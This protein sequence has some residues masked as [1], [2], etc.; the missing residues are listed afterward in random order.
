MK[1]H[2]GTAIII[3]IFLT[4]FS[5]LAY[6]FVSDFFNSISQS[7]A[8][9]SY[10]EAVK[11]ASES[12]L[13]D[14]MEAARAYNARLSRSGV[15]TDFTEKELM[16]YTGL[17]NLTP[18]GIM[19][20]LEIRRINVLLPIYHGTSDGALQIGIGHLEGYS[21]PVGGG[22]THTVLT[23]HRGLPSSTLLTNLDRLIAGDVFEIHVLNETLYYL[24]DQIL[25]V[26]PKDMSI[27]K[28]EPE[29][30]LCTI[31]TCTPYGIN[32]HRLLVRGRR[33]D[34]P[35]AMKALEIYSEATTMNTNWVLAVAAIPVVI[36]VVVV[37]LIRWR[38]KQARDAGIRERG[39]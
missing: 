8:V 23:G 36:I 20:T 7:R 10:G 27:L 31:V 13:T 28:I 35:E 24:V 33:I 32:S 25:V 26:E 37:Q 9:A 16:E 15:R 14:I 34:G 39:L 5:I 21:L 11:K 19:G 2:L 12:E 29:M 3:L 17:L 4:G 38:R 22:S 30:D 6:P 18:A 1:K